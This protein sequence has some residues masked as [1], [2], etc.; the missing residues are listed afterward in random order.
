MKN[1]MVFTPEFCQTFGELA[2]IILKLFK[3][4]EEEGIISNSF[5][6][7]ALP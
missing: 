4:L 7:P 1:L 3:K 6:R 2:T 5:M